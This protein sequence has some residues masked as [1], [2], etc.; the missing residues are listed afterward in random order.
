MDSASLVQVFAAWLLVLIPF[1]VFGVAAIKWGV[2]TTG[3][4]AKHR[5]IES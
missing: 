5:G 2:Y 1:V 4:N 3:D